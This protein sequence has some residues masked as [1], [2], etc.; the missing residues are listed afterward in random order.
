MRKMAE[1]EQ[2]KREN[3]M[4]WL[5]VWFGLVWLLVGFRKMKHEKVSGA[6]E[7]KGK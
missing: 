3:K 4:R 2:K 7:G 5:L 6:G 1:D